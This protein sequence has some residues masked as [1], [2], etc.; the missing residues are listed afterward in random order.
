MQ[1]VKLDYIYL[2]FYIHHLAISIT[3]IS[4]TDIIIRKL[5]I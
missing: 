2:Y 5:P 1:T 3:N 4:I